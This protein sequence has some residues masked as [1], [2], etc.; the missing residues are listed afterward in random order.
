MTARLYRPCPQLPNCPAVREQRGTSA[1]DPHH[2]QQSPRPLPSRFLE[3]GRLRGVLLAARD[4]C[5]LWGYPRCRL[6]DLTMIKN[7]KRILITDFD[8][9][10]P[11]VRCGRILVAHGLGRFGKLSGYKAKF[12]ELEAQCSW[13]EAESLG[14]G[15]ELITRP[16]L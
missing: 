9:C 6:M 13:F 3:H 14:C 8:C 5:T 7:N 4:C 16:V 1:T 2:V 10:F 15:A 11:P 12:T